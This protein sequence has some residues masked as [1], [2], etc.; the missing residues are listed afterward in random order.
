MASI[1]PTQSKQNVS[2][3][4]WRLVNA[5]YGDLMLTVISSPNLDLSGGTLRMMSSGIYLHSLC[6]PNFVES[7]ITWI[8]VCHE[9]YKTQF[10]K[11]IVVQLLTQHQFAIVGTGD[12][13]E[14]QHPQREGWTAPSQRSLNDIITKYELLSSR[15]LHLASIQAV[16]RETSYS[17]Q[18]VPD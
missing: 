8:T 3:E 14:F 16:L 17:S 1:R 7:G 12:A 10:S 6:V 18:H 4:T 9:K 15:G 5:L 2:I 11:Q 13:G